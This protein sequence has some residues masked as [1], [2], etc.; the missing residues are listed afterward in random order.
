MAGLCMLVGTSEG[1]LCSQSWEGEATLDVW[2][3]GTCVLD[4]SWGVACDA[5]TVVPLPTQWDRLEGLEYS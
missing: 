5:Q 4:H 1:P 2:S 3:G